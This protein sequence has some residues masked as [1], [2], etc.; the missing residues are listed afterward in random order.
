MADLCFE[1]AT[2]LRADMD[3]HLE[4]NN[5]NTVT[6]SQAQLYLARDIVQTA[7]RIEGLAYEL[8]HK[9]L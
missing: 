4:N 8:E 5:L 1:F 6:F 9:Q 7:R 2:H 3:K